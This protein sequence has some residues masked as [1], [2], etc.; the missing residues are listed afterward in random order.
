[1]S[2][3][4]WFLDNPKTNLVAIFCHLSSSF[5]LGQLGSVAWNP[6]A[7]I[8]TTYACSLTVML[9][10]VDKFLLMEKSA[11][12]PFVDINRQFLVHE[13]VLYN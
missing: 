6:Y 12:R 4:F 9:L 11:S 10:F 13:R 7:R 8:A 3:A 5:M 2:P 1:M